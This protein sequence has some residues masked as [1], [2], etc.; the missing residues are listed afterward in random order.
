MIGFCPG[1]GHVRDVIKFP[2]D[3]AEHIPPGFKCND[4]HVFWR[5]TGATRWDWTRK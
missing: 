4:G 1:C 3:P 5:L 2:G